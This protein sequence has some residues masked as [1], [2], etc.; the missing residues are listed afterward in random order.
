MSRLLHIIIYIGALSF[1]TVV[2]AQNKQEAACP[3][4]KL[5][6]ERLPD[7]NVLRCGHSIVVAN[8]E[9]TVI[10]GHTTNFKPTPTAEYFKDGEWHL[11][12]TAF[13]HDDGFALLLSSGKVLIAGGHSQNMGIG[14]SFE[15]ELYDPESH[16]SQGFA[17]LDTKRC[18]AS[19]TEL[20]SGRVVVS[21]NWY[22]DDAIE[23]FDGRRSFLPLKDVTQDRCTPY[24]LRTASDD[25]I[26]IGGYGSKGDTINSSVADRLKGEAISIPLMEEWRFL[27]TCHHTTVDVSF[28]GDE[29]KGIYT[30]LLPIEDKDGKLAIA[31][32]TNGEFSLLPTVCPIPIN[33]QEGA[34]HW[35]STVLADRQSQK[36]YLLGI[37]KAYLVH[38]DQPNRLYVLT[39]DYAVAPA[40]MTLGYTAPLDI[41]G[42]WTPV[43]T[44][45]GNLMITGGYMNHSNFK[46]S[47][48][49]WLLHVSQHKAEAKADG[50]PWTWIILILVAGLALA[51]WFLS[52]RKHH[53]AE[54]QV[55]VPQPTPDSVLMQ[56][57]CE[58][59]EKEKLFQNPE[60]K[61]SDVAS[62][63]GT[64]R[65]YLSDCINS[66]RDC[67]FTQFVNAYRVEYAKELLRNRPEIKIS[68]VYTLSGFSCENTFFRIFKAHTGK[69]PSE[70]RA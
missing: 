40:G 38:P 63:L 52:W 28:I 21:G 60:L 25:A 34:I 11:V 29:G 1:Q 58:L 65:T 48:N 12:E 18:L 30:Y 14:Q 8:G 7:L 70:Y 24:I 51:V 50:F 55:P 44:A 56:R 35:C 32:V 43:L 23:M 16:T 15:A 3:V 6:A 69:T 49:V 64:N 19:A 22:H 10:G 33:G 41:S 47:A 68:E 39:I 59:M 53:R 62:A 46:P 20:D 5:E 45:E 37:D 17:S 61:I 9:V 2:S 4:V 67:S 31:L 13:T 42:E 36:A 26:I 66:Q 57:I 27:P 54:S